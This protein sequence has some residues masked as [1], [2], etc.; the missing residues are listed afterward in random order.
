MQTMDPSTQPPTV[1]FGTMNPVDSKV[2][3]STTPVIADSNTLVA[4]DI[5]TVSKVGLAALKQAA[6]IA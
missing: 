2:A 6:K 5:R 1:H 3:D 4:T